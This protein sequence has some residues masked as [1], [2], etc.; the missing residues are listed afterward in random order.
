MSEATLVVASNRLDE[1]PRFLTEWTQGNEWKEIILVLDGPASMKAALLSSY[2]LMGQIRIFCW[3]DIDD[4]HG[5]LAWIFSRRDSAIKCYG[6]LK[7]VETGVEH[8]VVLDD[9]CYLSEDY[10]DYA[11]PVGFFRMHYTEAVE[12]PHAWCSTVP[13][14]RVRG[15]PYGSWNNGRELGTHLLHMGLWE[16]IPDL[17][18]VSSLSSSE[19]RQ[20]QRRS[21]LLGPPYFEPPTGQRIMPSSQFWPFCGMSF[22]FHRDA[23]PALYFPLM[24]EGYPYARFDDI[25]CGLVMQKVFRDLGFTASVGEPFVKHDRASNTMVNLVKEAAGIAKNERIWEIIDDMPECRST[26]LHEAVCE[27]AVRL[28]Q[29]ADEYLQQWGRA[30][31]VWVDLCRAALG[32]GSQPDPFMPAPVRG[33]QASRVLV[34]EELHP[35][36]LTPD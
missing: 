24:G 27:V 25:W 23:L 3:D 1:L 8:V 33:R 28:R 22:C 35:R 31:L 4:E 5:P 12:S 7:A 34:D 21:G 2:G 14:M 16:R 10:H 20:L 9:D 19:D 11:D 36:D 6:F 29:Q 18:S 17:D 13:G 32:V 30:L 15:L 26:T